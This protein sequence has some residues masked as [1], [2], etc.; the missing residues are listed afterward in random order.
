MVT[1]DELPM[2][3]DGTANAVNLLNI[4]SG[5]IPLDAAHFPDAAFRTY[6]EQFDLDGNGLLS[7]TER[8][9]V[10]TIGI[11]G[12]Q[13]APLTITSIAGIEYFPNLVSLAVNYAPGLTSADIS[14]NQALTYASFTF[15]G[16]TSFDPSA[17]LGLTG[18]DLGA[19]CLTSLDVSQNVALRTL[20]FSDNFNIAPVDIS[21]NVNL[22]ILYVHRTHLTS[23][24]ISHNPDLTTLWCFGN[25]LTSLDLS[26]HPGLSNGSGPATGASLNYAGQGGT[27]TLFSGT[28]YVRTYNAGPAYT[29]T[30]SDVTW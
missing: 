11:Y 16:L 30:P 7:P 29:L 9:A 6:L 10:T 15:D 1:A 12:T 26:G 18:L 23:L 17:N 27:F 21:N 13:T 4:I 5:N 2:I 19:N 8:D 28:P 20:S 14:Q 25:Q 3:E 22:K 24:D